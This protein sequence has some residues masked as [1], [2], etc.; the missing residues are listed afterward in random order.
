MSLARIGPIALTQYDPAFSWTS[1]P[2]RYGAR[3]ASIAGRDEWD[4]VRQVSEL[5][6]NPHRRISFAD[7]VGVLVHVYADDELLREFNGWYLLRATSVEGS[8]QSSVTE[9]VAFS[10]DAVYLGGHRTP[11]V[12][13][14]ARELPDTVGVTAKSAVASPVEPDSSAG[15]RF[16][17]DPGGTFQ[18]REYDPGVYNPRELAPADGGAAL[19]IYTGTVTDDTDDLDL[20]CLP[21]I[22]TDTLTTPAWVARWGQDVRAWDRRSEREV[23][24]PAHPF[25]HPTDIAV[26]NGLIRFWVG[27]RGLPP[28]LNVEAFTDGEWHH[29]G[30]LILADLADLDRA[31]LGA[32]LT[33][34]TPDVTTVALQARGL[35]T[36]LCSLRR[37]ERGIRVDH[38]LT[39]APTVSTVRRVFW[40]GV[41]PAAA[42]ASATLDTGKFDGAIRVDA[43]DAVFWW[44]TEAKPTGYSLA[45][46]WTPNVGTDV[47][48]LA[49]WGGEEWGEGV[50]GGGLVD[51][52]L[53]SID[54]A[55]GQAVWV[56]YDAD[57]LT[58][59]LHHDTETLDITLDEFTAAPMFFEISFSTVDGLSFSV[60]P[61]GQDLVTATDPATV[62]PATTDDV[63]AT[64][65]LGSVAGGVG[66][67]RFDT[68]QIYDQPL[69]T[70][71]RADLAAATD[72]A[73]ALPEPEAQLVWFAP[74]DTNPVP[75][76][77]VGAAGRVEAFDPDTA[78]FTK[79]AVALENLGS[80]TVGFEAT[81]TNISVG[82]YLAL[83][84][85]GDRP[86]DMHSQFAAANEQ[87]L[88]IR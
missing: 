56:T 4:V 5:V 16:I 14:S 1:A 40:L 32:R 9:L 75:L 65:T 80:L 27:S 8:Q 57:T 74:F 64:L 21:A 35:G 43:A 17:V 68:V 78:G 51:F 46:W 6:A 82:A 67:G 2:D 47:T 18:T 13:R 26:T 10:I 29:V 50:W 25:K 7:Y 86:A 77:F 15:D 44:P 3:E 11:V 49:E 73:A 30:H 24:G 84:V 19:A 63:F 42:I 34:V 60:Q 36:I 72:R 69:T 22:D 76:G 58:F 20:V 45:G 48:E 71:Q 55:S 53:L 85:D 54:D 79:I 31:L 37:G 41:P 61:D 23:Y 59:T 33:R 39:A 81:D 83:D 52:T 62:T 88:R 28:Y 66:S 70:D 12:V 87:Q 38:G